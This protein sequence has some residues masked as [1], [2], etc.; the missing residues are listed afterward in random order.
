MLS[1]AR[2]QKPV[3]EES[4]FQTGKT[5]L[6]P[7]IDKILEEHL[8]PGSGVEGLEH[9]EDLLARSGRGESCLML[10]EHYSNFDLPAFH[11]LLRK[12]GPL[13]LKLADSVV[14]IAGIK[15]NESN[16]IVSAF[17]DAYTRII[18]YPSRSLE[19]IKQNFKDPNKLYHEMRRSMSI[20]RA[21]M[22]AL[23]SVKNAGKI[24]LVFPAGTRY[25][26]G[27]PASKRGVREIASYIKSFDNYMPVAVNGNI[28][29][30]NPFG[31]MEDDILHSDTVVYSFGSVQKCSDL[32]AHVKEDHHFRED[33]K[34]E[35]VDHIMEEL[36]K[37][38]AKAEERRVRP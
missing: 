27:N 30:I 35:T 14:A 32:L 29:R 18:I 31:E 37:M 13:G 34:Q 25:R 21:A 38:H 24:I 28:L 3:S 19:I 7:F 10:M 12:A 1:G 2:E 9:I 15:L 36:E 8:L 4:V 20:N 33:K 5:E 16:P 11:Y 17:A 26:P 22:K 23:G 6:L